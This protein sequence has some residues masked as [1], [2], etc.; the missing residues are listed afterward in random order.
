MSLIAPIKPSSKPG[1]NEFDPSFKLW[2]F[3]SPP[4]KGVPST[5]PKKSITN[6]SPILAGLFFLIGFVPMFSLAIFSTASSISLVLISTTGLIISNEDNSGNSNSG[7]ISTDNFAFR[8]S[9]SSKET[10]SILGWDEAVKLLLSI[11]SFVALST[12]SLTTS[13]RTCLP[14]LFLTTETGTLP[15]L[16]PGS[17]AS[18]AILISLSFTNLSISELV[19][20]ISNSRFKPSDKVWV[21]VIL[22]IHL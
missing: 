19:I 20:T 12:D 14:N 22:I 2:P 10:I 17:F 21:I 1:I 4:S 6:V 15:G 16:N 11:V 7:I 18:F 13:P 9:P 5:F 8:S 3:A